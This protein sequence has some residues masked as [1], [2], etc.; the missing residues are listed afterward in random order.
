MGADHLPY[1][2]REIG[3]GGTAALRALAAE[4]HPSGIITPGK[5][6]PEEPLPIV[7]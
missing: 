3:A 6:I 7:K 5:L 4:L 1:I 2:E